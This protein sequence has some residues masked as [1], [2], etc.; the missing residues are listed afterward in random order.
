L[1]LCVG[2]VPY[3]TQKLKKSPASSLLDLQIAI[4]A[5][6]GEYVEVIVKF[7]LS[8]SQLPHCL[9]TMKERE[10]NASQRNA[11]NDTNKATQATMKTTQCNDT[12]QMMQWK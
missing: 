9:G 12:M 1:S 7:F 5:L 11:S 6:P 3:A 8:P 10:V 2:Y 4:A